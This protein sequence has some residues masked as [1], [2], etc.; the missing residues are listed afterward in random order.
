MRQRPKS[1]TSR[2]TLT[3]IAGRN[4]REETRSTPLSNRVA[5]SFTTR[6]SPKSTPFLDYAIWVRP[7]HD[8]TRSLGSYFLAMASF[9]ALPGLKK[10]ACFFGMVMALRVL[11]LTPLRAFVSLTPKVPKL[12]STT[13]CPW[14]ISSRTED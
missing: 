14:A 8:A 12:A 4:L 11:G 9:R 10:G 1:M 7:S 13:L 6:L 3:S 2:T 5:G